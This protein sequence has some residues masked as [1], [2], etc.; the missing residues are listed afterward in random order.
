MKRLVNEQWASMPN[1]NAQM[2]LHLGT[3]DAEFT[4]LEGD[5][6][7]CD[8]PVPDEALRGKI[9]THD[10]DNHEIY[11]IGF[12]TDCNLLTQFHYRFKNLD[13]RAVLQGKDS[14]GRWRV[15]GFDEADHISTR[16]PAAQR[17]PR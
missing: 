8:R 13:G 2:P 16:S 10:P 15:W 3:I 9:I 11:G 17:T 14:Q 5:C 4:S 6:A 7:G 1:L 12:C